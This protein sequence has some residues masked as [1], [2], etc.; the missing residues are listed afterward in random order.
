MIDTTPAD[1]TLPAKS[2]AVPAA[3]DV[4]SEKFCTAP[5]DGAPVA[6]ASAWM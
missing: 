5:T 3:V 2:P 6:K 4:M 1:V